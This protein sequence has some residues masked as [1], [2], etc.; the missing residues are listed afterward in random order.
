[1][2]L[3]WVFIA[4]F[5]PCGAAWAADVITVPSGQSVTLLDVI[6]NVPG[7]NGLT[8]R[9]RFLAPQIARDGG[10][11]DADTA[12]QDMNDLCQTYVLPKIANPGPQ[13]SQIIISMSDRDVPFGEDHPEATQFFN[14]YSI[15]DGSC[16]WDMF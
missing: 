2:R 7:P 5:G 10:T 13:P 11:I 4:A 12:E 15:T 14:S 6:T 9:F 1:M 3:V 8:S 16:V